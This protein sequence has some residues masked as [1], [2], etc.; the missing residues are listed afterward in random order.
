MYTRLPRCRS[1]LSLAS[2]HTPTSLYPQG[3]PCDLDGAARGIRTLDPLF[4]KEPLWPLS[5]HGI[6]SD[7]DYSPIAVTWLRFRMPDTC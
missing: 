7:S 4:T 3:A 1:V 2:A 6:V 5:Y